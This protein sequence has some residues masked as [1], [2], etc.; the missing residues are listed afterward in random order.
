MTS[1][2]D[3]PGSL[4]LDALIL[5]AGAS[6]RLGQPKQTVSLH[7]QSLLRHAVTRASRAINGTV[8]V[9]LGATAPESIEDLAGTGAQCHEFNGWQGGQAASLRFGLS[10]VSGVSA[11]LVMLC[12]QYRVS[13][14]DLEGLVAQWQTQPNCPTAA[15]FGETVGVPVIW[16]T[17]W[18]GH[19]A[20]SGRGQ[21][22]LQQADARAVA[23]PH[24]AWDLDT[25]DDLATLRAYEAKCTN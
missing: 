20:V 4:P 16:P 7:G 25:P 24:A 19:L 8:H 13:A 5:A 3:A 17:N 11:L 15:Q 1:A 6:S 21:A 9:V 12:D 10:R 2:T 18:L 14:A 22:L 23:M